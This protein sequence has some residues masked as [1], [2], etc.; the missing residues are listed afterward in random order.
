LIDKKAQ[1]ALIK[2]SFSTKVDQ[3]LRYQVK[4]VHHL[5]KLKGNLVT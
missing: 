3:N 2:Q 4:Q 5:I 1:F